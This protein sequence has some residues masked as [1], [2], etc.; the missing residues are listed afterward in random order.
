M[1]GPEICEFYWSSALILHGLFVLANFCGGT[2]V[3]LVDR[4]TGPRMIQ[5]SLWC[6]SV[7]FVAGIGVSVLGAHL[8]AAPGNWPYRCGLACA[9]LAVFRVPFWAER[10][11]GDDRSCALPGPSPVRPSRPAVR[12]IEPLARDDLELL[13]LE[14]R[15]TGARCPVCNHS[16]VSEPTKCARCEAPHHL[17]CFAYL[18]RCGIYGCCYS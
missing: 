5:R 18:G 2:I 4:R 1:P 12:W 14:L 13:S 15:T 9:I 8:E 16:I 11:M 3:S 7:S 17:D 10:L 6:A